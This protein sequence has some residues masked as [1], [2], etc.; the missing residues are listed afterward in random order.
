METLADVLA[1]DRRSDDLALVTA[2]GRERSYREVITNAYRGGNALRH[3]GVRHGSE[4][5]IAPVADLPSVLAFLGAGLLGAHV[6]FDVPASRDAGARA[7]VVP[8]AEAES[9]DASPGTR[10]VAVGDPPE[11]PRITHWESDVWSENPAFP[12]TDLDPDDPLVVS[13]AP[14]ADRGEGRSVTHGEALSASASLVERYGLDP[15]SRVV[16]RD[17][18]ARPGTVV[19]GLIAPLTCGATIVLRPPGDEASESD[20]DVSIGEG[21]ERESIGPE[22]VP[23]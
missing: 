11:D 20:G 16:V 18:L 19:A 7:L 3:E 22:D 4:V 12:P 15:D 14:D 1:R 8:T 6:R 23:V 17:S 5:G 13:T 2:D 10:I 21:P 9:L